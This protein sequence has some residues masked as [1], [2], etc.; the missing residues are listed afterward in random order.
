MMN[1]EE[2]IRVGV[3]VALVN[4]RKEILLELRSDVR[5]WGITGGKLEIGETPKEAGCREVYE[6]TGYRIAAENLV[7]FNVYGDIKEGR[8]IQYTDQRVHLID[9]VYA[10]MVPIKIEQL[11]LSSESLR[12]EYYS[13]NEIQWE[14]IVPP[15]REPISDL[16]KAGYVA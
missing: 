1:G 13:S 12:F 11:I 3:G 16:I 4:K 14:K 2:N 6:E 7:L 9:I 8:I 10:A 15:A 5:M